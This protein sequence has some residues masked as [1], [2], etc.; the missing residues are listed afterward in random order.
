[1]S[2]VS[3]IIPNYNGGQY[4]SDC[5]DSCLIQ[6]KYVEEIIV[7]DDHSSD[8]SLEIIKSYKYKRPELISYYTNPKKGACSA[9]N[10]GFE[11][12]TGEFIQFLDSDDLLEKS[13]IEKQL[14]VLYKYDNY[15]SLLIHGKWGRFRDNE[16]VYF[17][18]PHESISK[19]L[20]PVDWMIANQMSMTGCWLTHRNLI[21]NAG[22][23]DESLKRNQDGE[24]YSRLMLKATKVLFCEEAQ[25][26]Y[27]SGNTGSISNAKSRP[28][29]ESLL[30][31]YQLVEKYILSLEVS[32][33]AK[34]TIAN[35][36]QD[37]V[38]SNY[39]ANPD[40]AALAERK[41][42]EL[43]GSE[44]KLPGGTVLR[45]LSSLFGWKQ[46]LKIKKVLNKGV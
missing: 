42:K 31:S 46:A 10:F 19:D 14:E 9:R 32:S 11:K 16:E 18:G 25:V 45:C 37:F 4:L 12:S 1:M 44:L 13:K 5:L 39:I 35:M 15:Q 43:G 20:D 28:S 21:N 30:K 41:V 33:R 22:Q 27:R 26:F 36:Y 7:I 8:N 34:L 17:W 23:W 29:M 38:Y 24:F 3:I 2:N 6:G 40:L